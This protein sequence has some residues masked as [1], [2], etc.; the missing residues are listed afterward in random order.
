VATNVAEG[1]LIKE[2]F[3]GVFAAS[4]VPEMI[5]GAAIEEGMVADGDTDETISLTRMVCGSGFFDCPATVPGAENETTRG[6]AI[7]PDIMGDCAGTAA[8]P[9]T[10]LSVSSISSGA[11]PTPV[12]ADF[13]ASRETPSLNWAEIYSTS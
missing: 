6:E 7:E 3:A 13:T 11:Q 4:I 5:F 1:L 9:S 8:P 12:S 10:F 2:F